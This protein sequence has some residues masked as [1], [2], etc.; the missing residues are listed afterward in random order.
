MRILVTCF[1]LTGKT[2][3]IA[4]KLA[5][6][7]GAD[8]A[9]LRP[10][11][12]KT[13]FSAYTA[14]L[15]LAQRRKAVQLLPLEEVDVTSYD[16]IVVAGPVWGGAPAPALNGFIRYYQLEGK[17]TY[18]LL[19]CGVDGKMA[20]KLL[21]EEL[22][23]AR[24]RCRSIITVRA[25]EE[26]LDAL[27]KGKIEFAMNEKGKIILQVSE[28]HRGKKNPVEAQALRELIQQAQPGGT[29]R[30]KAS[31]EKKPAPEEEA[32]PAE[33]VLSS[34]EPAPEEK[35]APA[36]QEEAKTGKDGGKLWGEKEFF[37]ETQGFVL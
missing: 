34:Q 3:L 26:T 19:S 22:E 17:Q 31:Q 5:K 36:A 6:S 11:R 14:G 15:L 20:S 21:R 27:E 2:R 16:C 23:D 4:Q 18:G 35:E 28:K 12:W 13:R 33:E 25:E 7:L 30:E 32:A 24:T 37:Q 10:V 8:Y 1:S 9:D 29:R